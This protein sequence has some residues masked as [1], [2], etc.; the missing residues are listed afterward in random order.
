[1]NGKKSNIIKINKSKPLFFVWKLKLETE[2]KSI[3]LPW[4][5]Q[6]LSL[7]E[8]YCIYC[9]IGV[10]FHS[11][12]TSFPSSCFSSFW[13][14]ASLRW[15][16]RFVCTVD[17]KTS[18]WTYEFLH[19][20]LH[21]GILA[22]AFFFIQVLTIHVFKKLLNRDRFSRKKYKSTCKCLFSS[23][24]NYSKQKFR[25]D[26]KDINIIVGVGH[27]ST[28]SCNYF[29]QFSDC[30]DNYTILCTFPEVVFNLS[31]PHQ[32]KSSLLAH[33]PQVCNIKW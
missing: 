21:S 1:M 11:C 22:H 17:H 31:I 10:W 7:F 16:E 13:L 20:K 19:M 6:L 25:F 28:P 24:E 33:V 27:Y 23:E 3:V 8:Y 26:E 15:R 9:L 2:N 12:C 5:P 30:N 32:L 4:T 29:G 18:D 14:L